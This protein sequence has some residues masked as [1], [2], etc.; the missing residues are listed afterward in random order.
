MLEE[1]APS[2]LARRV[3][4]QNYVSNNTNKPVNR[5]NNEALVEIEEAEEPSIH[6]PPKQRIAEG[7][8]SKPSQP[9]NAA[10][11]EDS[12]DKVDPNSDLQLQQRA[13]YIG[14]S[15]TQHYQTNHHLLSS[16]SNQQSARPMV[17]SY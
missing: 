17:Q 1:K 16:S 12:F 4:N 3:Q 15:S 11:N 5:N 13:S 7:K 9:V 6:M 8:S 2:K 10:N 14:A